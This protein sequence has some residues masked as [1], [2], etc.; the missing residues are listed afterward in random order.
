M[1]KTQLFI[2]FLSNTALWAMLMWFSI[3]TGFV[4]WI[5]YLA[6]GSIF[7]LWVMSTNPYYIIAE[8]DPARDSLFNYLIY[9]FFW[10]AIMFFIS[11]RNLYDTLMTPDDA[12]RQHAKE[13]NEEE[14]PW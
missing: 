3:T 7:A 11:H 4:W 8:H 12:L 13:L 10:V 6:V 9:V 5:G 1:V 2:I 14:L